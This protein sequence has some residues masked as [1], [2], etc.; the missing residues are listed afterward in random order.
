MSSEEKESKGINKLEDLVG[1]FGPWQRNLFLISFINLMP[2]SWQILVPTFFTPEI[3]HWCSPPPAYWNLTANQ[4][5]SLAIPQITSENNTVIYSSCLMY[6]T[7]TDSPSEREY[8]NVTCTSWEYDNSFY[9]STIIDEW[10]LVCDKAWLQSVS[11]TISMAGVLVAVFISGQLADRFG[12]RPVILLGVVILLV[13]GIGCAFS[14]SF[15]VFNILRFL[16]TFGATFLTFSSY[17]LMLESVSVKYRNILPLCSE[18]GWAL[19]FITLPAIAWFV[20]D[21]SNLQLAI[22]IPWI[23]LVI[24]WWFLPESLR[25]LLTQDK[26]KQAERELKRALILNKKQVSNLEDVVKQLMNKA[27]KE[28]NDASRK[29]ATFVDLLLTPN[30]RKKTLNLYFIWFVLAFVY[31]G[32]SLNTNNLGGNPFLN[33][34]IAGAVEFPSYGASVFAI[35]YL[36]RRISGMS[37]MVI[38]GLACV[39]TIPIPDD[40]LSLRIT[41][42]MIGKAF[43]SGAFGIMIVYSSEIFPTVVRNVG[44]GSSST[45]ARIGSMVAPFAVKE[46]GKVT[47][48]RVPLGI[49]GG[50]S[51]FAGL[52]ILL[53]PET[54]NKP[55]SDT[56][57]EGEDFGKK[58]SAKVSPLEKQIVFSTKL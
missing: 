40:L 25:W 38:A 10:N 49:F 9:A 52:L 20:G 35:K 6:K 28:E 57:E 45:F 21:W 46:L 56:L 3:D 32:L 15:I 5:K 26:E 41:V 1:E 43:I 37:T 4:W 47:N 33:F 12:R 39:L 29:K 8:S 48:P 13:A 27:N 55:L 16:S 23:V 2:I 24:Y 14:P 50:F 7:I 53:L 19:G 11:T 42:S 30:M 31:Y 34:F 54:N 58:H 51:I 36:G 44:V 18:F 22:T 17:I